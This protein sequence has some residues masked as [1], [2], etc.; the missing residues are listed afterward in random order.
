[1]NQ[2]AIN[3]NIPLGEPHIVGYANQQD[4]NSYLLQHPNSTQ[5]GTSLASP[6][7]VT[8]SLYLVGWSKL[9][10]SFD[11]SVNCCQNSVSFLY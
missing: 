10:F 1:V 8:T 4:V 7:I 11:G 2:L 3:N 6:I 5:G 9:M